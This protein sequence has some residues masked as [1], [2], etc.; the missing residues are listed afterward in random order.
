MH[1][2]ILEDA[3]QIG[4][5]AADAI[6][7][8]VS[9]G[10]IK[11]LGVAT[12]SSPLSIY[13]A[14]E[15]RWIPGL[16]ALTVFALDEYVGLA[17]EHPESY[18]AV[19]GREITQRLR[20][21]PARVHVP[22]GDAPD[23]EAACQDFESAITG[24]GGIDLQILGIGRNGHIGFNE[25]SSSLASRTRIKTLMSA[26]RMD[27]ARFFENETHVPKHCLTQGLGTIMEAREVL[28]VAQGQAKADAIA[29]A[30]EGPVSS[31]CPASILQ[32]HPRATVVMDVAAAQNLALRD[33][34]RYVHENQI[35]V[36]GT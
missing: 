36:A 8:G 9:S 26:S 1:I 20:M 22:A 10:S 21:D 6:L 32:L 33:Y 16:A 7:R 12:G 24:A 13:Q 3:G 2:V 19:I 17:P 23:L 11:T 15:E 4:N 35:D 18:H 34:Y 28:L 14:L 5:Y 25:P 30:V 31:M 29:K 27:N